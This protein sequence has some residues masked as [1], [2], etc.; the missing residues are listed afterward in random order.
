MSDKIIYR[1]ELA[2]EKIDQVF[3]VCK[4]KGIT[5]ALK[6]ELLTKPAIM[7]HIDVVYQQF[8]KLEKAQEYHILDK[9]TKEDL[10]GIRNIR[11][12][13]SHD[14]DNIQ[15]EIIEN[16]IRTNLPKLKENIQK[17]LKE[18]KK[19]MCEDL[20]KKIDRFVKKQDIL[21]SQ[22]KSELKSDIQK[23]YDILQ[24]NGLELDKTYTCKLGSIIK[25]NSNENVR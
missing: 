23:S 12:W 22:A 2:I 11:N 13:S 4:P 14:Y 24:K 19:D 17:V 21:T 20:Q 1:L 6:D 10:K 25:D 5:G 16:V 3:E 15:N 8:D 7:K 9:F 18:T